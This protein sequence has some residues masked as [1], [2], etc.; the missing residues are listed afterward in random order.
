M[1]LNVWIIRE[2][3]LEGVSLLEQLC[4]CRMKTVIVEVNFV[5]PYAQ[6]MPVW[7]TVHFVLPIDQYIY[8]SQLLH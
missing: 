4:P 8:N 3:L 5:D 7:D 1:C 2:R 6:T